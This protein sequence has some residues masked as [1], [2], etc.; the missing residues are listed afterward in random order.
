MPSTCTDTDQAGYEQALRAAPGAVR[1]PGGVAISECLH[2]VRN[3]GE[4]ETLGATV[5]TVAEDLAARVRED[6]DVAAARELGYLGAAVDA[7]ASHSAGIAEELARRVSV[8]A[9]GLTDGAAP[10]VKRALTAGQAAGAAGG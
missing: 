7:G 10:A 2:R 8:A 5:N 4:L 1:L 6:G 9:T 3:D